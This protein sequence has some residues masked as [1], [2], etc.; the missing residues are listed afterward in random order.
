MT[1]TPEELNVKIKGIKL[2]GMPQTYEFKDF[3]KIPDALSFRN[4][5]ID[6]LKT[7][8]KRNL[9]QMIEYAAYQKYRPK[10]STYKPNA[11]I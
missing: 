2:N 7:V 11:F 8:L 9:R 3:L 1:V 6:S 10:K 4:L 5:R